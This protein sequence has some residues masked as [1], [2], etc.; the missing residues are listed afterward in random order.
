MVVSGL[1][2]TKLCLWA[3]EFVIGSGLRLVLLLDL[4][5]VWPGPR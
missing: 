2:L 4:D 5:L 1:V 3:S